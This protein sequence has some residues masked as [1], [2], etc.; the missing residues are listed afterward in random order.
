LRARGFDASRSFIE[1]TKVVP[2]KH[3]SRS[4]ANLHFAPDELRVAAAV[5]HNHQRRRIHSHRECAREQTRPSS[6]TTAW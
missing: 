6:C 5:D 3:R 1:K 4:F 2:D